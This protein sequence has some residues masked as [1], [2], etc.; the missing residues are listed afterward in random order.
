MPVAASRCTEDGERRCATTNNL[1]N[2]AA[3][4]L[5]TVRWPSN[6]VCDDSPLLASRL[7]RVVK[8]QVDIILSQMV[9]VLLRSY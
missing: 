4:F 7:E 1:C 5:H 6:S 3:Q 2:S 9:Y 8:L